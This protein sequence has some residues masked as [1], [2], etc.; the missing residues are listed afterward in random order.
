MKPLLVIFQPREIPEFLEATNKLKIDKLWLKFF[1]QEEAYVTARVW[2]LEHTEYTHFV[3]LPDDLIV[4]QD[5]I[6]RLINDVYE[7]P[8]RIIS[9]WCN[10]TAGPTDNEDTNFSLK[11]PPIQT[12]KYDL[13]NFTPIINIRGGDIIMPVIHQGTAL[14]FLPRDIVIQIPF[15]TYLPPDLGLTY[16]LYDRGIIQYVDL[17]VRCLHLRHPHGILVNKREKQLIFDEWDY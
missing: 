8:D 2:F 4:T 13:Y 15:R 3:I 10:N 6:L 1:P 16:D 7:D 11:L 9:G 14:T 17:R 5:N 12:V